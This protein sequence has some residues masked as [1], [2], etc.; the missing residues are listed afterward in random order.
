[1]F[2]LGVARGVLRLPGGLDDPDD[3]II[4]KL[5]YLLKLMK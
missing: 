2:P 3:V 5:G 4:E 1:M